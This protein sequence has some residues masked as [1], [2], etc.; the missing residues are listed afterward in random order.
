LAIRSS[1][2]RCVVPHITRQ[3]RIEMTD[4]KYVVVCKCGWRSAP[5]FLVVDAAAEWQRHLEVAEAKTAG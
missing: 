4:G 5:G 2:E 1:H 3:A